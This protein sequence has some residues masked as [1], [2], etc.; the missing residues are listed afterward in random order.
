M[1]QQ[2]SATTCKAH[3]FYYSIKINARN[4]RRHKHY[5]CRDHVFQ[6]YRGERSFY[7]DVVVSP[8]DLVVSLWLLLLLLLFY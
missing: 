1:F 4:K 3:D 2:T 6:L 8:R 7:Q 5:C